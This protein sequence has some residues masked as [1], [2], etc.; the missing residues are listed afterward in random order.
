MFARRKLRQSPEEGNER[1]LFPQRTSADRT[2]LR[3]LEGQAKSA[4]P[5]NEAG[6]RERRGTHH[7]T[8]RDR[9]DLGFGSLAFF[10]A[11]GRAHGICYL[12]VLDDEAT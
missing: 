3:S 8:G 6:E 7:V 12:L 4:Q 11:V 10:K 1:R 9:E 5:E 2:G